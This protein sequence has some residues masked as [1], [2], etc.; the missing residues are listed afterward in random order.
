M[1]TPVVGKPTIQ[2]LHYR[3]PDS[4]SV[5]RVFVDGVEVTDFSVEDID[6]GRGYEQENYDEH[7][8]NAKTIPGTFGEAVLSTLTDARPTYERWGTSPYD[9]VARCLQCN[10][11]VVDPDDDLCPAHYVK[12]ESN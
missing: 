7:V 6:P 2:I 1:T 8:E 11:P 3:D 12:M 4:D 9:D 5:I 10:A